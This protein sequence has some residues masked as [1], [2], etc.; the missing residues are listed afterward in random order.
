MRKGM[1][2]ASLLCLLAG[3]ARADNL[4]KNEA[5]IPGA[6]IITWTTTDNT[7]NGTGTWTVPAGVTSV[8][9]LVVAGGGGGGVDRAPGGG[10]GG[11]LYYGPEAPVNGHSEGVSYT[12]TPGAEL[13]V[14]VGA[15]GAG[16]TSNP[17][18]WS[19]SNG[20]DSIFYSLTALGGGGSGHYVPG[21]QAGG[22]GGGGG[23]G[24]AAL[25]QGAA[26]TAGQGFAGGNGISVSP[27]GV[28]GGG[29]AG[30]LGGNAAA[31]QNGAGGVGLQYAI[32][33]S[34]LFYAGGGGGG[35]GNAGGTTQ[36]GGAGGSGVGGRGGLGGGQAGVQ[37]TDGTGSGG[38]GG[39]NNP[40]AN[41]GRGGSG[42]VIVSYTVGEA[43]LPTQLVYTAVPGTGVAGI[44]FSVTVE[45]RDADGVP[46]AVTENTTITLSVAAGGGL[47]SGGT[48][49]GIILKDTS[50]ILIPGVVYDTADTMTLTATATSGM[51]GLT[52]VTSPDIVF[53]LPPTQL[54]YTSVPTSGSVRSPFS[55]TVQAR[56][57]EGNPKPVVG[58]T[59]ITLSKATGSG[60][61]E[62]EGSTTTGIIPNGANNVTISGVLYDT[63]DTMT[64]TATASG[65]T[66]TLAPVTSGD[67][68]FTTPTKLVY[69]SVPSSG[70]AG[71]PF[72]VT[73]QAQDASGTPSNVT[74]A[75]T[76]T[77]SIGSGGGSLGRGTTT[78]IIPNA[79][80]SVTIPG[81][82]YDT[83]DTMTL[84]ATASGGTPSLTAVTSDPIAFASP[85][86][87]TDTGTPENPIITW[88]S[89]NHQTCSGT[90]IVPPGVTSVKVLVVGGGGGG[91]ADR[92][93]GGGAGGLLYY[94]DE[95]PA[96]GT[97]YA[98]TPGATLTVQIGGGGAGC[99]VTGPGAYIVGS[100]GGN[101]IFGSLEA[102][103]GGGAGYVIPSHIGGSGAGGSQSDPVGG[104]GT[105]GQG[106]AGGDGYNLS[107]PQCSGG[108]GGAGG[109][110]GS[111]L[112]TGHNGD[113]GVG[114]EYAIS[115][116]PLFYAGGG[117]A[118]RG[119]DTGQSRGLGGSGV[120]GDGANQG[121]NGF[122]GMDG[123]GGGGGGS[124]NQDGGHPGGRGGSGVVIIS[125]NA[126]PA[127]VGY[128][129]WA[130]DK[131]LTPGVN[132][133]PNYDADGDGVKN[134]AEF[135]FNGNPLSG[136]DNGKV[137]SVIA[138]ASDYNPLPAMILTIA[139]RAGT[140]FSSTSAAHLSN[141][142]PVDGLT[143][144]I[145]G[146]YDLSTF[147]IQ[148]KHNSLIYLP[149]G[150]SSDPGTN[151]EFKSFTLVGSEMPGGSSPK[152]FLRAKVESSP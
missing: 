48:T 62:L 9:V 116:T 32:S 89:G 73:V 36:N 83:A 39:A 90:W 41:G 31:N 1:M 125:Y 53:A 134:V 72:S 151:Y 14:Q 98:V 99:P 46:R 77:L 25:S 29:G 135:A 118:G 117:G 17:W 13:T 3:A 10:A 84:T 7:Q 43:I 113:G 152:G 139:V 64:L 148:V 145:D 149:A 22:S 34:Q 128:A 2:G 105:A 110:G 143:Y 133:D 79:A 47:L 20:G 4:V 114:L 124:S 58:N 119:V 115:G 132:D 140:T 88:T 131:G 109:V 23:Q 136:A 78:G 71:A 130:S 141:G 86:V 122:P 92:A 93:P 50:G 59:T 80:N 15:G 107:A 102:I 147:G 28:G 40:S 33:G 5:D 21:P 24:G 67:I 68:V 69:T 103:G 63:A 60:S 19:G 129:K 91:G 70:I 49:T 85:L 38:G 66:T 56:D 101:S 37:G 11:L 112:Q 30:G 111:N 45:A 74:S 127:L 150:V 8:H 6:H 54:V 81:V 44:P 97:S 42:V 137:Y 82:L 123:R 138:V 144:T 16:A 104:A 95:T 65:G 75:T 146:T 108:G 100:D 121:Q 12:V 106:F 55:V 76:I 61:L 120:G 94:G 87:R 57:S 18:V 51:T 126:A 142:T 35:W 26:G 27:Q 52:A 96:A